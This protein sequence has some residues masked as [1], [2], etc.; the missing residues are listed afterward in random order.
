MSHRVCPIK[1]AARKKRWYEKNKARQ[2]L[3]SRDRATATRRRRRSLLDF[4]CHCCENP[5]QTVIQWHHVDESLK[6]FKLFG[7]S[8]RSENDWWNEVLKC[9]PVCANCHIKIHKDK[10]CLLPIHL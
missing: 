6:Q 9:I 3:L 5:D 4:P 1:E 10:L 7:G 8:L 2:Q